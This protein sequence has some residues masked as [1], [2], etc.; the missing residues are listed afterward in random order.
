M[1]RVKIKVRIKSVGW[2]WLI[3]FF[4]ETD[5]KICQESFEK[6]CLSKLNTNTEVW[7]H[8]AANYRKQ[9][10]NVGMHVEEDQKV[11][12]CMA[13][14]RR[15]MSHI[16]MSYR[17]WITISES[18]LMISLCPTFSHHLNPSISLAPTSKTKSLT[19]PKKKSENFLY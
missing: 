13:H 19:L 18:F 14:T 10:E 17:V 11:P 12:N 15:M 5:G 3:F 7:R 8:L 9:S 4:C 16:Y 6:V 2:Q 1:E